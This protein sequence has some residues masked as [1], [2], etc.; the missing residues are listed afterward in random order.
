[1][2]WI[3]CGDYKDVLSDVRADLIFTSP[4]YNIGSKSPRIDGFRKDGGYDPKS[5]GA[6]RDYDDNL[7]E[8]EY[9]NQQADFLI[10]AADHLKPDGVLVY[11]HKPR[12]RNNRLIHPGKWFLRPDVEQRLRLMEECVWDRGSTHNHCKQLLWPQTE[13]LYV[14]HRTDGSYRL[15]D[16]RSRSDLWKISRSSKNTHCA[17]FPAELAEAVIELWSRPGDLVCDPYA[18]SGTTAVAA[19]KLG[20]SFEG[21]EILEKYWLLSCQNL[22]FTHSQSIF[23][24]DF[25]SDISAWC[26]LANTSQHFQASPSY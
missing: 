11:N 16:N 1:M 5:F 2:E 6:I 22:G 18:G 17:A 26:T 23:E 8:A 14:F 7:P 25:E 15:N 21:A 12:R 9:Q 10:W 3:H 4:P 13:R 20:R 24:V 19:Q